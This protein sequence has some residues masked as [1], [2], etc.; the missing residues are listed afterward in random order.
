MFRK[1]FIIL[2]LGKNTAHNPYKSTG[3]PVFHEAS[4]NIYSYVSI[5]KLS[6]PVGDMIVA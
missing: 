5:P 6:V 3:I 2:W 4:K 1:R